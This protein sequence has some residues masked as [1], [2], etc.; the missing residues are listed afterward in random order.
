[1]TGTGEENDGTGPC[2]GFFFF[3]S[4]VLVGDDVS[5]LNHC[6]LQSVITF[7]LV[8]LLWREVLIRIDVTVC[9]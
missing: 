3:F 7:L 2:V 1:M 5:V 4:C 8:R 9:V 6:T